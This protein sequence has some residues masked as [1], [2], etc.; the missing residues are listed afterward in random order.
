MK[1]FYKAT[2]V[3]VIMWILVMLMTLLIGC[4][5]IIKLVQPKPIYYT[6]DG[7]HVEY[8]TLI[9]YTKNKEYIILTEEGWRMHLPDSL[10]IKQ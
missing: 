2:Y 10:I 1:E 6:T 5:P 8:G 7:K 9:G 3:V 4:S